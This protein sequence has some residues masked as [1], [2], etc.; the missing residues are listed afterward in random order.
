[1]PPY[2]VQGPHDYALWL[3]QLIGGSGGYLDAGPNL[4][5][6]VLIAVSGEEAGVGAPRQR[7]RFHD[8]TSLYFD[9]AVDADLSPLKHSSTSKGT[10][11]D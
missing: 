6:D 10:A 2:H 7:L 1:M 5:V 11:V 3:D 8:D 9:I 4:I